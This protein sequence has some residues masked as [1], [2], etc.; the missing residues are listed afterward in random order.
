MSNRLFDKGREGLLG[1]IHWVDDTI[2]AMLVDAN[3][4]DTAIKAVVSASNATPIVM[5]V[6]SHGFSNGDIVVQGGIAGN[7]AANGTFKV[8]N[9]TASTYEI[10]SIHGTNTTGNGA[11]TSGGYAVNL[12]TGDNLDDFS[13]ARVGSDGAIA[14]KTRTNG[15]ADGDDVTFSAVTGATVE[16]I[17]IYKDSG[18]ESTSTVIAWIDGKTQVECAATTNSGAVSL[19]ILPLTSAIP[20]GTTIVFSNGASVTMTSPGVVGDRTLA[21]SATAATVT[22]GATADV[23]HTNANLPITP[24]G[25]SITVTWDSGTN[26]IFRI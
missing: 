20:T 23:I 9:V 16:G 5:G 14:N 7:T 4:A 22:A 21:V 26:K 3:T 25:G 15:V 17:I 13:A 19:P 12:T 6:T 11:Y 1:P 18:V 8:A 2:K 10:T 24:N